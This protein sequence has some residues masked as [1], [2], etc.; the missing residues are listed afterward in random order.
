VRW[1][2]P[3]VR[4]RGREKKPLQYACTMKACG[5]RGNVSTRLAVLFLLIPRLCAA[6]LGI[7]PL[8][9]ELSVPPGGTLEGQIVLT[10]EKDVPVRIDVSFRDRSASGLVTDWIEIDTG[11]I[12]LEPGESA[13][14]PYRVAVPSGAAGEFFGRVGFSEVQDTGPGA[15]AVQTRISVPIFVAVRGTEDYR[16]T[17]TGVRVVSDDPLRAEVLVKNEGNVHVRATGECVVTTSDGDTE[18]L[19]MPVNAQR[20]PLYPA[21][22]GCLVAKTNE[23]LQPGQYIFDIRLRFP[24]EANVVSERFDV[25]VGEEH[26]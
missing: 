17:I 24:D 2:T 19:R 6:Y 4:R 20:F 11:E 1:G 8:R 15:V 21:R 13:P 3:P 10:N 7:D 18:V 22:V 23:Q 12:L 14:V 26:E 9:T 16:A 25:S 5:N